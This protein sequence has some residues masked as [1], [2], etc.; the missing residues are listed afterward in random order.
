METLKLN[1]ISTKYYWEHFLLLPDNVIKSLFYPI[2]TAI[3]EQKVLFKKFV[4]IVNLETSTYCNRKC[5]Y[6]P[7]SL[8]D[9]RK[10]Q[11]YMTEELY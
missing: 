9:S 6:C 2:D 1:K 5:E 10:N 4:C 3:D 8:N 11:V 7:V